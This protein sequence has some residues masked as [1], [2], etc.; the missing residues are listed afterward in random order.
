L[1]RIGEPGKE[2][3]ENGLNRSQNTFLS[4]SLAQRQ[5]VRLICAPGVSCRLVS[6]KARD[7]EEGMSK[8]LSYLVL[9]IAAFISASASADKLPYNRCTLPD[10][11]QTGCTYGINLPVAGEVE[12]ALKK[13]YYPTKVGLDFPEFPNAIYVTFD[14]SQKFT[15]TQ[16]PQVL[17]FELLNI[18]DNHNIWY[19][20]DIQTPGVQGD[21]SSWPNFSFDPSKF[22][23]QTST[24]NFGDGGILSITYHVL[25]PQ[26][27]AAQI[28]ARARAE[29]AVRLRAAQI[30]ALSSGPTTLA[31]PPHEGPYQGEKGDFWRNFCSTAYCGNTPRVG[32]VVMRNSIEEVVK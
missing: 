31:C 22:G 16:A 2:V 30:E 27:I 6:A 8:A 24:W 29:S 21:Y 15:L 12:V 9:A 7:G 26:Q 20:A 19:P 13:T 18:P 3:R 5:V 14:Q 25:T 10:G 23:E 4:F 32:S 1:R 17:E 11:T 28:A